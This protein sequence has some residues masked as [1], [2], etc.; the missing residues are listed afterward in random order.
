MSNGEYSIV[1]KIKRSCHSEARSA[2]ESAFPVKRGN[3]GAEALPEARREVAYARPGR[4]PVPPLAAVQDLAVTFAPGLDT[5][6]SREIPRGL[7]LMLNDK[8]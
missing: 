1:H 6:S 4:A 2:E 7:K 5:L 3:T 8:S